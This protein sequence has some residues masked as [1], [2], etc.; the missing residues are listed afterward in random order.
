VRRLDAVETLG[1]IT[2]IASDKTGTLTSGS[3]RLAAVHPA[4]D[5]ARL[6][7]AACL[8]SDLLRESGQV[9]GIPLEA[10]LDEAAVSA[11]I[12]P[13]VLQE[14]LP[15]ARLFPFDAP[16]ALMS[17]VRRVDRDTAAVY[18]KGA[19]EAVLARCSGLSDAERE[20]L[21]DRA[22]R[23][24]GEGLRVIAFAERRVPGGTPAGGMTR[25]Q[26]ETGLR[27]IALAALEDPPRPDVRAA[28]AACAA[29]G[30]RTVMITGDHP[31]T[32]RAV[33]AAVGIVGDGR[34]L[35]GLDLE[36]L[37]DRQL[38]EEAGQVSLFARVTP[39]A[40]LR[41]VRAL[42]D[43]GDRVAVT[44]DGANDAPALAAADI[45]IAMGAT[46]SDLA[47]ETAAIVLADDSFATIGAAVREGRVLFA[48][49]AKGV[50]YYLSCK[51]ALVLAALLPVLLGLP[52]PFTPLQLILMELFMDLAAAAGFALEKGEHD[53]MVRP[54]RDPRS[55]FMDAAMVKGIFA[56]AAGLFAA[57]S[58]SYLVLLLRGRGI[59]AARTAAFAAWLLGHV[60]LAFVQRSGS[61]PLVRFGLGGN[62]LMAAWALLSAVCA[63]AAVVLPAVQGILR[64]TTL[65]PGECGLV[66]AAALAGTLWQD[67][68][69]LA[70]SS[71]G[72]H[73]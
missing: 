69:R 42:Q 53:V 51:V 55:R 28:V 19:P 6:L 20:G 10:A 32:A 3:M 67:I 9:F 12:Q 48:N 38:R 16:R 5:R 21:M 4:Q 23:L 11:G 27:F 29:A 57:V 30:I 62:R 8:C 31:A 35:T 24:A 63:A 72:R 7:E 36:R 66:A 50:R 22:R 39:R 34:L 1:S 65:S 26:A 15:I 73:S 41:I 45:G 46:G 44:G 25:E 18:T 64:T 33:A 56:S 37:D 54:P 58:L 2:T 70:I 40:K 68:P 59:E 13:R 61:E 52:I 49:L 14:K 43:R 47:R 17:I 60:L 71:R